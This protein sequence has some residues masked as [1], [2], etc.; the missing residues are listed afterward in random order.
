MKKTVKKVHI[1]GMEWHYVVSQ[2]GNCRI[3]PPN[4]KSVMAEAHFDHMPAETPDKGSLQCDGTRDFRYTH[5]GWRPARIK[6]FIEKVLVESWKDGSWVAAGKPISH[7]PNMQ[8]NPNSP[9]SIV[10]KWCKV[11]GWKSPVSA[12]IV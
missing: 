5:V 10:D 4:S 11:L 8:Q 1:D 3:F 7:H 2:V 12:E 9:K 6:A